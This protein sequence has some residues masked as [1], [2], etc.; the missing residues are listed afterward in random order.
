MLGD[1]HVERA[2]GRPRVHDFETH[3]GAQELGSE[4]RRRKRLANSRAEQDE[5]RLQVEYALRER[6]RQVAD[7]R[8]QG[9]CV[10]LTMTVPV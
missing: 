5:V 8:E 10:A 9:L 3:P 2:T 4:R 6:V 1:E 7:L